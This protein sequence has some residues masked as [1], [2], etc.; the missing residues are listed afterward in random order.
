MGLLM[1]LFITT[2]KLISCHSITELIG[3]ILMILLEYVTS[4]ILS[5]AYLVGY[6]GDKRLD[7][8][9]RRTA[10]LAWS[11]STFQASTQQYTI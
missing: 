5:V 3:V 10:F 9:L 2:Y 8:E 1:E 7:V 6:A 4:I 11:V